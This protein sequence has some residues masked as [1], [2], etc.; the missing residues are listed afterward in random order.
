LNAVKCSGEEINISQGGVYANRAESV[1]SRGCG[2]DI[3]DITK[4]TLLMIYGD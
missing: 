1:S 2:L 3:F 4:A